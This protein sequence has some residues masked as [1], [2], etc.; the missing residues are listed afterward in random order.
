MAALAL[1]IL[2]A[3]FLVNFGGACDSSQ[4]LV[5]SS[6]D[7]ACRAP[8]AYV[9][10]RAFQNTIKRASRLVAPGVYIALGDVIIALGDVTVV[11]GDQARFV[12]I[13]S[14]AGIG[15]G[16]RVAN[17]QV[18]TNQVANNQE[19]GAIEPV[20]GGRIE[21]DEARFTETFKSVRR[22]RLKPTRKSGT[23][24]FR[25]INRASALSPIHPSR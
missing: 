19:R 18:A 7:A 21:P 11:R 10:V 20:R 23:Q 24:T 3:F 12:P 6:V 5:W 15:E 2:P 14:L 17:N 25:A 13:A 1:L 22:G 9:V 8:F 4:S 16:K